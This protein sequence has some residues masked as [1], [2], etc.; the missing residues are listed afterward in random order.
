MTTSEWRYDCRKLGDSVICLES[1]GSESGLF[2]VSSKYP[3]GGVYV[4]TH[5]RFFI[6]IDNAMHKVTSDYHEAYRVW[7]GR[8]KAEPV[9]T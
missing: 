7:N 2:Q 9:N 6:W 4:N 8:H 3:V 1:E 5:P